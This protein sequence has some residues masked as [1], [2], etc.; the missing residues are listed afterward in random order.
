MLSFPQVNFIT[1]KLN[2]N[3]SGN[4]I[5]YFTSYYAVQ[6]GF[7]DIGDSALESKAEPPSY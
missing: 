3:V 6:P 4:N 5:N 1:L 2:R 7:T